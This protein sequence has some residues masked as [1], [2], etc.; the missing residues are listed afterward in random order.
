MLEGSTSVA[1][2]LQR[3]SSLVEGTQS[4]GSVRS[5]SDDIIGARAKN[6]CGCWPNRYW[7]RGHVLFLLVF[8]GHLDRY[9]I[10]VTINRVQDPI[11]KTT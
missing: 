8:V 5:R 9:G 3:E 7:P 10:A 2:E 11:P 6:E 4:C 1:V